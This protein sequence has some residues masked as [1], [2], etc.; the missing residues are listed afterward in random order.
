MG[1]L[2]VKAPEGHAY[3]TFITSDEKRSYWY[4]DT[5]SVKTLY[6]YDPNSKSFLGRVNQKMSFMADPPQFSTAVL[7]LRHTAWVKDEYKDHPSWIG[8]YAEVNFDAYAVLTTT[9]Q[10]VAHA[11]YKAY[12]ASGDPSISPKVNKTALESALGFAI[13]NGASA[14]RKWGP[15]PIN[16]A[17]LKAQNDAIMRDIDFKKA[18]NGPALHK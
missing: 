3:G 6:Y 9:N 18:L 17:A 12:A 13:L 11:S 5:R 14:G 4:V 2:D 7:Q 16:D 15:D 10:I 8:E 1:G